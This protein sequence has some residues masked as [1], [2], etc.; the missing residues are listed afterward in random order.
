MPPRDADTQH[1][2]EWTQKDGCQQ[3][4]AD[5][6]DGRGRGRAGWSVMAMMLVMMI[7]MSFCFFLFVS[8]R[9]FGEGA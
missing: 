9:V 7:L 2:P 5:D 1:T 6:D 3:T 4:A 8:F